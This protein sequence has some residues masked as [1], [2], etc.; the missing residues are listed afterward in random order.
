MPKGKPKFTIV[1]PY[2]SFADSLTCGSDEG[3]GFS[4]FDSHLL[5]GYPVMIPCDSRYLKGGA[6]LDSLG[7]KSLSIR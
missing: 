2:Y 4:N 3:V 5:R 7:F 6:F 1:S